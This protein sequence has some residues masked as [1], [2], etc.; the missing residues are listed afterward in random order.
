MELFADDIAFEA[1]DAL[2][3]LDDY[4]NEDFDEVAEVAHSALGVSPVR[5]PGCPMWPQALVVDIALGIDPRSDIEERYNLKPEQLDFLLEN[6]AFRIDLAR[7]RK[8]I[9]ENGLSF[10]RKAAT[11]AEMYLL[12]MDRIMAD[13]DT[14]PGIKKDIFVQMARLGELEPKTAKDG[15]ITAGG[16]AFNIQINM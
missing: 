5:A 12:D 13:P 9:A 10:K 1:S 11:Q 3:G 7:I 8:E 4:L 15:E 6:R 2:A 16:L 14:P